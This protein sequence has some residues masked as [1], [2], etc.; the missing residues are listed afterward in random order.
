MRSKRF[1]EEVRGHF[2]YVWDHFTDRERTVFRKVSRREPLSDADS[3]YFSNLAR[4]GCILALAVLGSVL[5]VPAIHAGGR[6]G[7]DTA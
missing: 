4:R 2:E 1:S 6:R 7:C 5:A 3:G